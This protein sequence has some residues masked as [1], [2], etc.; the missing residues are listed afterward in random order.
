MPDRSVDPERPRDHNAFDRAD[1]YSGQGYDR[2]REAAQGRADADPDAPAP[3]GHP[4][5]PTHNG[6]RAGID[7]STGEV[8]GAGMGTGGGQAGEDLSSDAAAGSGYPI[9]GGEGADKIP[10]ETGPKN[11]NA[12]YL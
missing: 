8:H 5:L 6:A 3:D 10:G 12:G 1:G 2:E 11:E 9:S 7:P 4:G